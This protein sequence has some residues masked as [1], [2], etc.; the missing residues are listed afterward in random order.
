MLRIFILVILFLSNSYCDSKCK[1]WVGTLPKKAYC[2]EISSIKKDKSIVNIVV[3]VYGYPQTKPDV[4]LDG[5]YA[6]YQSKEKIPNRLG[7]I[8]Y[9]KYKFIVIPKKNNLLNSWIKVKVN[10]KV[11][12][13][14]QINKQTL[15]R[16]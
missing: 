8:N 2:W 9:T 4:T 6:K 7:F 12:D 13:K 1:G 10:N 3:D 15:M 5:K 16:W 11:K 14:K